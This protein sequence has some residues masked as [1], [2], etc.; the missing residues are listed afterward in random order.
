MTDVK[1]KGWMSAIVLSLMNT[2]P[3]A[4]GSGPRLHMQVL[5]LHQI[6]LHS[7]LPGGDA[8]KQAPKVEGE[9]SSYPTGVTRLNRS[10]PPHHLGH[11]ASVKHLADDGPTCGKPVITG[12]SWHNGRATMDQMVSVRNV[13]YGTQWFT[14]QTILWCSTS[15]LAGSLMDDPWIYGVGLVME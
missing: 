2:S 13:V 4:L 12:G 11:M 15:L 8:V 14:K 9:G 1:G 6:R 3:L 5:G 7:L 10:V